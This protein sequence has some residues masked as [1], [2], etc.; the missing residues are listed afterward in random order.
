MGIILTN[1]VC[2]ASFERVSLGS[3]KIG[4]NSWMFRKAKF[5]WE[6]MLQV[7]VGLVLKQYGIT[8][9][10]LVADDSDHKRSK[11]TKRI[12]KTHKL[13]DKSSGGYVNGQTIMLLL[14]VTPKVTLPVGFE[15][16]Q[17]DPA[18]KAWRQKDAR[19]KKQGILCSEGFRSSVN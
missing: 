16:Y 4:A 15:F 12:F 6:F 14:L 11:N 3:Y 2:W 7:A 10:V 18:Q 17:P 1:T 9:G 8:E 19:L 13:K 5:P